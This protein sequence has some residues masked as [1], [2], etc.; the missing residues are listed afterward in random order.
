MSQPDGLVYLQCEI[1]D[2]GHIPQGDHISA[3]EHKVCLSNIRRLQGTETIHDTVPAMWLARE[4][5]G[6]NYP[7]K[8]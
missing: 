4:V 7:K 3:G 2:E 6:A 5:P 1:K 8:E